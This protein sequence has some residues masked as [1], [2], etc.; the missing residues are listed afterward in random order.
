MKWFKHLSGSLKDSIIFDA[1]EK[2]GSDAYMV[3]F[4][5]LEILADEFDEEHPGIARVSLKK[6]TSLFQL[7]RQKTVKILQHF[8]QISDETSKCSVN[9]PGKKPPFFVVFEGNNVLITCP[10]F[11]E[12]CDNHTAYNK[13]KTSKQLRSDFEETS[14]QEA[15]A[16]V[17]LKDLKAKELKALTALLNKPGNQKIEELIDEVGGK[18]SLDGFPKAL[19]WI[20]E[21]RAGKM[22][23][24]AILHCLNRVKKQHPP[25]P[26]GYCNKILAIENGNYNES[27]CVRDHYVLQ[28]QTTAERMRKE[29]APDVDTQRALQNYLGSKMKA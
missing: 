3:F 8:G 12:L 14:T 4:G 22:N 23:P 16:E 24:A 25:N 29:G 19:E 13:K 7:S 20:A 26:W 18:L 9:S 21:K 17:D 6:M 1:V 10:R 28:F 5:T 2:F 15:E 27:E 11:A